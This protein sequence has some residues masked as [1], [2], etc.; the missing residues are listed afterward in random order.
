MVGQL[1]QVLSAIVVF[2]VMLGMG[3]SLIP[4]DFGRALRQPQGVAIG[5]ACQYGIMPLLGFTLVKVL[6]LPDAVA[7]GLLIIACMPGGTTSNM[8]TYFARGN[9]ALSV[10][11]TVASTVCGV[12]AIPMLLSLYAGALDLK[13]P[14]ENIVLVLIILML[15]VAIGMLIRRGS[16]R[17]GAM[18][19][20]AGSLLGIFFILFLIVAWVPRNWQF[21]MDA[22][23]GLYVAAIM[24]GLAGI[25]FGYLMARL[26]RMDRTDARTVAIETGLQNGPLAFSII[27]I[28][29]TGPDQQSYMAVPALYSFFIVIIATLVV[30]LFRAS[31]RRL[32]AAA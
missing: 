25:V 17:A 3:A 22:Q 26:L 18:T 1:E 32:P 5:L 11:M 7:I 27:A 6:D 4:G 12:V 16:E 14:Q 28:T 24:L 30:L 31:D 23:P 2:F 10:L 13:I 20:R 29:F 15:P 8:F 19:E 9:L 21:L